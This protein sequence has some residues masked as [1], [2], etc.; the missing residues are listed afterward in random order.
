MRTLF[1]APAAL[2]LLALAF[3]L[4]ASIHA[5]A[6]APATQGP[7]APRPPAPAVGTVV[8]HTFQTSP[9][10]GPG[11]KTLADLRGRPLLIEF[12]GVR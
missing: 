8:D 5:S 7:D 11:I 9:M 1:Q 10:N 12:W 3:T 2:A 4:P 6:S